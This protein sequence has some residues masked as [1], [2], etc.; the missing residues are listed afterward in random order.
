MEELP[1][2]ERAELYERGFLVSRLADA[3]IADREYVSSQQKLLGDGINFLE[4]ILDGHRFVFTDEE[5]AYAPDSVSLY[6]FYFYLADRL[7]LSDNVTVDDIKRYLEDRLSDLRTIAEGPETAP[8]S[9]FQDA[10]L[11]FKAF[12][13]AIQSELRQPRE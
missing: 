2:A 10:R 13:D 12:A 4:R 6:S 9:L 5:S 7:L 8:E 1:L 3:M 11:F